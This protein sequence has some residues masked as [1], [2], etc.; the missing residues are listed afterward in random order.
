ME[1]SNGCWWA[2]LIY[3][4]GKLSNI[5]KITKGYYL[6]LCVKTIMVFVNNNI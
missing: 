2:E 4:K 5:Y 1:T 3:I 6:V